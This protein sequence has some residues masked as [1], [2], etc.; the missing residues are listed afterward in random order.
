[1]KIHRS[2]M[3][4]MRCACAAVGLLAVSIAPVLAGES[5]DGDGRTV[6]ESYRITGGHLVVDIDLQAIGDSGGHVYGD[7]ESVRD[8][9][10]Y[11]SSTFDLSSS[12]VTVV[13]RD[14]KL[15]NVAG[16]LE[17][18]GQFRFTSTLNDLAYDIG[19]LSLVLEGDQIHG[20]DHL[21]LQRDVFDGTFFAEADAGLLTIDAAI[22]LG[23]SMAD[24]LGDMTAGG[25]DI[26]FLRAVLQLELVDVDRPILPETRKTMGAGNPGHDVMVC[27]LNGLAKW[28]SFNGIAAYSIGTTSGNVGTE[29]LPWQQNG[30]LHPVIPQ[31]MYR[32]KDGRFEQIG[33][34][35]LK[36][37]FCALQQ[38]A[39]AF[40]CS[41]AGGGCP[42]ALGVGCT[43]PYTASRNGSTGSTLGPH[44]QVN[45]WTGQYI[46]P[47]AAADSSVNTVIRRRI[48]VDL[49]D[50]NPALNAGA[51]YFGEAK[52]VHLLD[53]EDNNHFNNESYRPFTVGSFSGGAYNL[54]WS[55]STRIEKSALNAWKEFDDDV[56]FLKVGVPGEGSFEIAYKITD[57]KDGTWHYE[58]AVFNMNSDRSVGSFSVP[59]PACAAIT[60]IGFHSLDYHSGEPFSNAAWVSSVEGGACSWSTQSFAENSD[61]NALRWGTTYNFRFDADIPPGP[62]TATLGLFK[63]GTPESITAVVQGP[64][65]STTCLGDLSGDD[66]VGASDLAMLLAAWGPANPCD[67]ADFDG[68]EMIGPADLAQLLAAW[69]PCP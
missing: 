6:Y 47:P 20:M 44:Y 58:Y 2:S 31:N 51:L 68:D 66:N 7:G 41:P 28:G 69:G 35:W 9:V 5:L 55:G 59:I 8:D 24:F 40:G 30:T 18:I 49:D 39:C 50:L 62:T 56:A 34:S 53:A 61:A 4:W 60:N 46:W 27:V 33:M 42:Q 15:Y 64:L 45:A 22:T 63:P 11:V 12:D 65:T 57:N 21:D 43:D 36:H 1:M 29:V 13:L 16:Q 14:G 25:T 38:N 26:G 17:T 23:M 10:G 67:P 48:Q 3:G 37:G 52:Y 54:S 19:D 32:L